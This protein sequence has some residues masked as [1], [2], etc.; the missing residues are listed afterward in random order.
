[1][2]QI[3]LGTAG[4]N[5]HTWVPL[6]EYAF[7]AGRDPASGSIEVSEE[8]VSGRPSA[9][10]NQRVY[11]DALKLELREMDPIGYGDFDRDGDVDLDD[12]A[13]LAD[14]ME[15]P[16]VPPDPPSPLMGGSCLGAFDDDR[17]GDIDLSDFSA[18]TLV[19]TGWEGRSTTC[20]PH[21]MRVDPGRR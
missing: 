4:A 18:F 9:T 3:P 12:Y 17:D 13:A 19:F 20:L 14:C 6:G 2:D 8:T 21:R 10:W 11:F 15:G 16:N 7:R 1:V 5:A